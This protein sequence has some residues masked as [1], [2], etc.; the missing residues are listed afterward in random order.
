M[1]NE[2]GGPQNVPRTSSMPT[3]RGLCRNA[4]FKPQPRLTVSA[5]RVLTTPGNFGVRSG[6]TSRCAGGTQDDF[7]WSVVT[8][9]KH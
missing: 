5:V 4:H 3:T 8:V 6:V 7:M 1:S 9:R 2:G